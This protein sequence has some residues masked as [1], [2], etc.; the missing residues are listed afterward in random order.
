VGVPASERL[1]SSLE[2]DARHFSSLK[3]NPRRGGKK[4]KRHPGTKKIL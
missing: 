2:R 1:D 3:H 4:H